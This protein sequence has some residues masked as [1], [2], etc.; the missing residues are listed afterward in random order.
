MIDGLKLTFSG[1]EVRTLLERQMRNQEKRAERWTRETLRTKED[2]TEDAPLLPDHMCE[3]EAERCTWRVSVLA[4]IRDHIEPAETYRL[5]TADLEEID[6][7]PRNL[8]G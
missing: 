6:S 1:E 3:N 2:E 7:C 4:F 5:G 8:A